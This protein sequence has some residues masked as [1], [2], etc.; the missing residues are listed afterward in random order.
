MSVAINIRH[1]TARDL[2]EVQAWLCGAG[3]PSEDLTAAHMRQFLVALSSDVRV[4][5]IRLENFGNVGLL[6][7]L[8][9][10]GDYRSAGIGRR[11][12]HALESTA[13]RSGI[14]ELWLLTIDADPFFS[15][16]DYFVCERDDA[17]EAIRNTDEFS[18]LCPGDAVLMRKRL[19]TIPFPE[20]LL[21]ILGPG[22]HTSDDE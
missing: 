11:L 1:A 16:L 2:D 19:L 3:L 4:G 6:R 21:A 8:V 10:D 22:E 14:V 5:M 17:P 12:V 7:S 15:R 20:H 18:R 9:V 13:A